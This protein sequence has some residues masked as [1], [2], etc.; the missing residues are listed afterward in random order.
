M[1]SSAFSCRYLNQRIEL[2]HF[3]TGVFLLLVV[4][5]VRHYRLVVLYVLAQ[6]DR[7]R[8]TTPVMWR[9]TAVAGHVTAAGGQ[10]PVPAAHDS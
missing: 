10:T 6:R 5:Q 8:F 2:M 1:L 9:H 3:E 7:D 4:E